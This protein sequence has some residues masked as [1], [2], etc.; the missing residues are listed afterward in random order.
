MPPKYR[1][2]S[3]NEQVEEL[4]PPDDAN[5]LQSDYEAFLQA[6]ESMHMPWKDSTYHEYS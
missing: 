2:K 1:D 5:R 4:K 6:F 3:G